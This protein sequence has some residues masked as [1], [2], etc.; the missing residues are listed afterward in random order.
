MQKIQ[1]MWVLES[2]SALNGKGRDRKITCERI[3]GEAVM[4]WRDLEGWLCSKTEKK[5]NETFFEVEEEILPFLRSILSLTAGHHCFTKYPFT[6][7]FFVPNFPIPSRVC[8]QN[9]HA[10]KSL[11]SPLNFLLPCNCCCY[12]LPPS[13]GSHFICS[14]ALCLVAGPGARVGLNLCPPGWVLFYKNFRVRQF[15]VHS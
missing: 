7:N 14:G 12:T 10:F 6:R 15:A 1:G 8:F 11:A 9:T 5:S 4:P 13:S 2:E 3:F